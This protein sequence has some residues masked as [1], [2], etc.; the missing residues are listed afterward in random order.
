MDSR[1]LRKIAQVRHGR[2]QY[3]LTVVSEHQGEVDPHGC[4]PDGFVSSPQ[5]GI[6]ANIPSR[7]H[8]SEE[9]WESYRPKLLASF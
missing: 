7:L 1:S 9:A 4:L 2:I 5:S 6:I 3:S 8:L